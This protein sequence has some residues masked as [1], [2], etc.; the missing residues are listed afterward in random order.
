MYINTHSPIEV[1]TILE[2]DGVQ[3]RVLDN[4]ETST[5]CITEIETV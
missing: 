5:G 4:T 3:V 2:R 1:N